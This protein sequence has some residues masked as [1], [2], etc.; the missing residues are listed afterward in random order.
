MARPPLLWRRG[1][2]GDFIRYEP[3]RLLFPRLR[4]LR[5]HLRLFDNI[6]LHRSERTEELIL[7]GVAH[8]Q[9]VERTDEILDERIEAAAGNS[10]SHV[11]GLHVLPLVFAR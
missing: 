3:S 9:L 1:I 11:R 8:L 2:A 6:F 7:L 5:F 4:P 10:H